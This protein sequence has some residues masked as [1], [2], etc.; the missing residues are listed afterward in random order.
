MRHETKRLERSYLVSE[1]IC[2]RL[3]DMFSDR[4]LR[5]ASRLC[6]LRQK[7]PQCIESIINVARQ[8][9]RIPRYCV[10]F[11]RKRDR[12]GSSLPAVRRHEGLFAIS[13]ENGGRARTFWLMRKEIRGPGRTRMRI[14]GLVAV[15]KRN[16]MAWGG[17]GQGNGSSILTG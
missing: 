16:F 4:V 7:V 3:L 8:R 12:G 6:E 5:T 2:F 9:R 1:E 14:R 17:G 13:W 15:D 11:V 10:H